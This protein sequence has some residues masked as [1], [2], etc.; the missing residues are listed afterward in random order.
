[1]ECPELP[2]VVKAGDQVQVDLVAGV[3]TGPSG[4]M[5]MFNPL[6]EH[7]LEILEAGGLV[8]KLKAHQ[9]SKRGM[10]RP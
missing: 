9:G 3:I 8:A 1:M 10:A 4:E 7:I 6:P 2:D 5:Y